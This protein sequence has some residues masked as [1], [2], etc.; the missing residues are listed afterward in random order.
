MNLEGTS[1]FNIFEYLKKIKLD[2]L[3]VFGKLE[4]LI[5][6]RREMGDS[7]FEKK[8]ILKKGLKLKGEEWEDV[9]KPWK[10]DDDLSIKLDDF[11]DRDQSLTGVEEILLGEQENIKKVDSFIKDIFD[12]NNANKL[13][14][15]FA[16]LKKDKEEKLNISHNLLNLLSAEKMIYE[17]YFLIKNKDN[18]NVYEN[19][20]FFNRVKSFLGWIGETE[21]ILTPLLGIKNTINSLKQDNKKNDTKANLLLIYSLYNSK[22]ADVIASLNNI[23][24]ELKD[25]GGVKNNQDLENIGKYLSLMKKDRKKIEAMIKIS[26]GISF[27]N[28]L[29]INAFLKKAKEVNSKKIFNEISKK[30]SEKPSEFF[31]HSVISN[32]TNFS[33]LNFLLNEIV[34]NGDDKLKK[35]IIDESFSIPVIFNEYKNQGNYLFKKFLE[36]EDIDFKR[37]KKILDILILSRGMGNGE[38]KDLYIHLYKENFKQEKKVEDGKEFVKDEFGNEFKIVEKKT[39]HKYTVVKVMVGGEERVFKLKNNNE[40][41]RFVLDN[42]NR[43][44]YEVINWDDYNIKLK[45]FLGEDIVF[46][47]D[48]E[49]R[50]IKFV[51]DSNGKMYEVSKWDNQLPFVFIEDEEK[52]GK[53]FLVNHDNE[54]IDFYQEKNGKKYE[55]DS[56]KSSEEIVLKERVGLIDRVLKK[57]PYKLIVKKIPGWEYED[58]LKPRNYQRHI[59][60]FLENTG[61]VLND[62]EIRMIQDIEVGDEVQSYNLEQEQSEDGRVKEIMRRNSVNY[63]L[64][65]KNLKVTGEHPFAVFRNKKVEWVEVKKLKVGDKLFSG[66]KKWIKVE[67]IEEKKESVDVFNMHVVGNN[68]YFV[69]INGRPILVHNKISC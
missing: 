59:A 11:S 68:N 57:Q 34:L 61:I 14:T 49:D 20:L 28:P 1:K 45:N 16:Q 42:Q 36:S 24:V 65:N 43:N 46:L 50:I 13:N 32:D 64:I 53:K 21:S 25:G 44:L 9:L 38:I 31:Y 52:R 5:V 40:I 10:K 18:F 23:I 4:H 37:R 39:E 62:G 19:D 69:K 22:K 33:I 35:Q 30:L 67:S 8:D 41:I 3:G 17:I 27:D 26:S 12:T 51:W 47:S 58:Y 55:I 2:D 54:I 48:S 56:W 63:F 66:N 15:L 29:I 7:F 6:L 60:C